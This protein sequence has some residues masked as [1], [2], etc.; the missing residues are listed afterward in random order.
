MW[1][2]A[3]SG[4]DFFCVNN[5]T[6]EEIKIPFDDPTLE[7]AQCLRIDDYE[8]LQLWVKEVRR[9]AEKNCK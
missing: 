7:N 6:E 2:C 4:H 5:K 3:K 1:Q 9:Y 8:E